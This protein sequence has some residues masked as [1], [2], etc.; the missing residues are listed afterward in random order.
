MFGLINKALWINSG[1]SPYLIVTT[2]IALADNNCFLIIT[3]CDSYYR[4]LFK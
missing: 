2:Y 3:I 4:V 1:L